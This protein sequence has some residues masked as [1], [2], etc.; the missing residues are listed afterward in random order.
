MTRIA[1]WSLLVNV[2]VVVAFVSLANGLGIQLPEF[3]TLGV[4]LPGQI[5]LWY[6]IPAIVCVAALPVTPAGLGVREHLFVWLLAVPSL[7]VKPGAA[8]SLSLLGYTVN[9]LW[10]V[11]GGIVYLVLPEREDIAAAGAAE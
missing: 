7:G 6:V 9:L 2:C 10:S 4:T 11:I 5:R 1:L 8:L 3:T